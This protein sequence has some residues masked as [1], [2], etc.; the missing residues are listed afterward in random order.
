[1]KLTI[2]SFQA[3]PDTE[4]EERKCL[5]EGCLAGVVGPDETI[6]STKIEFEGLE[7]L[8]VPDSDRLDA[9]LATSGVDRYSGACLPFND[10][11]AGTT[12]PAT[13]AALAVKWLMLVT[14][15]THLVLSTRRQNATWGFAARNARDGPT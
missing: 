6:H 3:V 15:I 13:T 5:Q 7:P 11:R 10:M 9:H 12:A 14:R 8:E 4:V 1:M 2:L